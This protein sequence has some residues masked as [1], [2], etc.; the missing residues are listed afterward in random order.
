MHDNIK[1]FF[2]DGELSDDDNIVETKE[3]LIHH[4]ETQMRDNGFVPVLDMDP[5]FTLDYKPEDEK[6]IFDLSIYGVKV[7]VQQSWQI[8]GVMNGKPIM[9]H[10][11]Q[12]K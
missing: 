4:L 12:T 8:S 1:K 5:Q 7:G 6:Y 10:T 2:Y 9:R 3:R 11:V